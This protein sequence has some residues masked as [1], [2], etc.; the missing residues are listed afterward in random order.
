MLLDSVEKKKIDLTKKKEK[1]VHFSIKKK[2][3][4]LGNKNRFALKVNAIF[5]GKQ[6]QIEKSK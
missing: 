1:K 5:S 3:K 2:S 6:L 4:N